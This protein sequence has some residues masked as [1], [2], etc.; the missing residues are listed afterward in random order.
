[1]AKARVVSSLV[2]GSIGPA[3]GIASNP[4]F[5]RM[6]MVANQLKEAQQ[7]QTRETNAFPIA[8]G[9]AIKDV[10]LNPGVN[11]IS[12]PVKKL[13]RGWIVTR[14]KGSI[15]LAYETASDDR[16]LSIDNTSGA[17][18]IDIWIY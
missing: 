18:T 9:V 3:G 2:T 10:V 17:V 7:S 8:Q 12:H 14:I 11:V 4:E 13:P 5:A 6:A 16:S 15:F 1:M